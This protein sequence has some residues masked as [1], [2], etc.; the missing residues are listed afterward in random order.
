MKILF[1]TNVLI[2]VFLAFK[3]GNVCYDIIDHAVEEHELYYTS[4]IITEFK[5]VFKKDFHYPESIINKFTT[6]ITKFFSKGKASQVLED[7]CRDSND[8]QI[9]A[10]ALVNEIEIIITGDKDL[11]EIKN[12]KDIKIISPKEYWKL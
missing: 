12:Y 7:V 9:L 4:F 10:D 11:L 3:R 1:D 6:F 5:R 2:S 8:N